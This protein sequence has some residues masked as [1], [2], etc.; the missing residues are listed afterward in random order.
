MISQWTPPPRAFG[1][2]LITACRHL[3]RRLSGRIGPALPGMSEHIKAILS[4]V[5]SLLVVEKEAQDAYLRC[6]PEP[7]SAAAAPACHGR[8][9]VLR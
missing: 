1:K 3:N 6:A 2:N 9:R 4:D 8:T 7:P 5:E